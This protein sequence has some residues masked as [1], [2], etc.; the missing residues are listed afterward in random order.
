M[1]SVASLSQFFG[2][3]RDD[4]G[5]VGGFAVAVVRMV[6]LMASEGEASAVAVDVL[7]SS[8]LLAGAGLGSSREDHFC[9]ARDFLRT[10]STLVA[11]MD[12]VE[13]LVSTEAKRGSREK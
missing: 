2:P 4:V 11:L 5:Y 7:L 13:L 3:L 12:D 1:R 9:P 6:C 10:S 8:L